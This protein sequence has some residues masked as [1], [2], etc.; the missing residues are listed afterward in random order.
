MRKSLPKNLYTQINTDSTTYMFQ[1]LSNYNVKIIVS[2]SQPASNA[3]NDFELKHLDGISGEHVV[4]ICWGKPV[5]K[6]SVDIGL[7]E[8]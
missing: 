1:N 7:V 8:G 3:S 2:D 4:G 6:V 5:G